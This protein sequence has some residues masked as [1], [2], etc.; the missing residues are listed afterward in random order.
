MIKITWFFGEPPKHMKVR[1]V[2]AVVFDEYGR[3]LLKAEKDNNKIQYSMIGGTPESYDADR[4]ATL[5]RE[6]LEEVNTTLKEPIFQ[7]GYQ[8][9]EGDRNLEPYAQIRMVAMIDNIG[10]KQ[11]D[12]DGGKTYDRILVDPQKAIN[13]LGWGECAEK[14][15]MRA[16]EI[17]KEKF[18]IKYDNKEE[19][20][21]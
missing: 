21:L 13:L 17:A 16:Y 4:I 12:P 1:Q 11:P 8:V 9:I 2:Y 5:K 6:F 19:E 7:V 10:K 18:N 15:I 20:W 3:T 14:P